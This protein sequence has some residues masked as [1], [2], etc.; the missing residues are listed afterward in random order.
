LIGQYSGVYLVR[1]SIY[2]NKWKIILENKFGNIKKKSE[3][4][5]MNLKELRGD[6]TIM[7]AATK[8]K[9]SIPSWHRLETKKVMASPVHSKIA[10]AFKVVIEIHPDGSISYRKP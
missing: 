2:K 5:R 9:T 3:Y 4:C 1:A 7:E 6:L 10:K 8:A